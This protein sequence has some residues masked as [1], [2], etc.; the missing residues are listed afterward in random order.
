MIPKFSGA[1][2]DFSRPQKPV[3]VC[4]GQKTIKTEF[5]G[6]LCDLR[7]K[8]SSRDGRGLGQATKKRGV[9]NAAGLLIALSITGIASGRTKSKTAVGGEPRYQNTAPGAAYVGSET[10]KEC[11]P[12][13]YQEYRQTAMGQS[14]ALASDPQQLAKVVQ[15][16]SIHDKKFGTTFEM[17][18]KGSDLYQSEYQVDAQGREIFRNTQKM[19]Y[20]IGA[21]ENGVGYIFPRGNYLLEAPL[22]YYPRAGT[23]AL[24]PG[25]EI[26]D[27]GF[28]RPVSPG[29]IA[30]HTGRAQPVPGG[31]GLYRE[32]PISEAAIGCE[33]C[34]G[35]GQLHIEARMKGAPLTGTVDPMI[36]NPADLP[37]W[38]ADNICMKCH[39]AGDA[40]VLKPGKSY[41]DFRP[42]TPLDKTVA[43]FMVPFDRSSPPK[44]PLLQHYISMILSKCYS[45]SGGRLHCI[46]CHDPH[47][48]PSASAAPEYFRKRCLKCHSE[49]SCSLP[50]K[51]RLEKTPPD[52]CAGCHMPKQNLQLVSHSALTNHRIVAYAGEPFPEAAFHMA[53]GQMPD[54]LHLDAIPAKQSAPVPPLILLEAY[55]QVKDSHPGYGP[56]FNAWL[57][58]AAQTNPEDAYV[59]AALGRRK[60]AEVSPQGKAEAIKLLSK[61]IHSGWT[62]TPDYALLAELLAE[63]GRTPE[64]IVVLKRGIEVNPSDDGLYRMLMAQYVNLQQYDNALGVIKQELAIFPQ[65]PFMRDL[66]KKAESAP[67]Q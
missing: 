57:D 29:C 67:A 33:N 58:K 47:L 21:G 27:F 9:R 48:Q 17:I 23:W 65:D 18:R 43:I 1:R 56:R 45:A 49:K 12:D 39:Q 62:E 42:G 36:V 4:Y 32:P 30:C 54:L 19:A 41:S 13:I 60:A 11:H 10:C 38:L 44:D 55:G 50:I 22:S 31:H 3:R 2:E 8:P 16:I 63:S 26:R 37:G 24:S 28:S 51:V 40:R 61:A 25:Y 59:L 53:T 15:P 64:G 6:S 35:P 5:I 7:D 20:V 34:H 46:T 66:L 52:D 14:M